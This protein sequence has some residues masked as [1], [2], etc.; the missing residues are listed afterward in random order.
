MAEALASGTPVVAQRAAGALELVREGVN[1][2]F[3]KSLDPHAV[4]DAVERVE[5]LAPDPQAC[6][7]SVEPFSERRFLER[8]DGV[9]SAERALARGLAA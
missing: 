1:G 3:L 7:A 2:V 6:R 8:I 9:L 4:I 5:R